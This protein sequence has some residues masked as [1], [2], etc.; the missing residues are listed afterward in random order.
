MLATPTHT[1]AHPLPHT[2]AHTHAHARTHA[3]THTQVISQYNAIRWL[4][5]LCI[6]FLTAIVAFGIDMGQEQLSHAKLS[7]MSK[8]M[9]GRARAGSV[10]VVVR[11]CLSA[12][13]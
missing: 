3:L 6:G 13:S 9:D 4:V 2:Y 1:C 5:T 10:V 12:C 7:V 11:V 8:C